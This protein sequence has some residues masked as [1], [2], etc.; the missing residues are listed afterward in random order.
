MRQYVAATNRIFVINTDHVCA[1]SKCYVHEYI[2]AA[3]MV[4]MVQSLQ[5]RLLW[6]TYRTST[7]RLA[8]K[9]TFHQNKNEV[10]DEAIL[11][12]SRA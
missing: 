1:T 12:L 5:S 11:R 3:A 2:F 6:N 9:S 8:P 4:G 10:C 7:G